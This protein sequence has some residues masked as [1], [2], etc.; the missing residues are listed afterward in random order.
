MNPHVPQV[1]ASLECPEHKK[2]CGVTLEVNVI[3]GANQGGLEVTNC[4]EFSHGHHGEPCAQ[5]CIHSTEAQ[6]LHD[7]AVLKH[8]QDLSTIGPN[9]IG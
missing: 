4:S 9:V 3:R 2:N 1:K 5:D 7:Q 6:S 8:Q